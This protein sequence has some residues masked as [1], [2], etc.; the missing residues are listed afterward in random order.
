MKGVHWKVIIGLVIAVIVM[1]IALYFLVYVENFDSLFLSN[2][3]RILKQY[4]TCALAYCATG[5]KVVDGT[6]IPSPQVESVGCL[7]SEGGKCTLSCAQ[8]KEKLG[9]ETEDADIFFDNRL[10]CGKDFAIPFEFSGI[11]LGGTVPFKSGQMDK[12]AKKPEWICKPVKIPFTDIYVDDILRSVPVLQGIPH[13]DTVSFQHGSAERNCIIKGGLRADQLG[14]LSLPGMVSESILRPKQEVSRGGGCFENVYYDTKV[15]PQSMYTPILEYKVSK[16]M[17][18]EDVKRISES[19][20]MYS[21]AIYLDYDS[22]FTRVLGDSSEPECEYV[23]PPTDGYSHVTQADIDR[24]VQKYLNKEIEINECRDGD[25]EGEKTC[26]TKKVF[27]GDTETQLNMLRTK[28]LTPEDQKKCEPGGF[29]IFRGITTDPSLNPKECAVAIPID[30]ISSEDLEKVRLRIYQIEFGD[31]KFPDSEKFGVPIDSCRFRTTIDGKK[32]PYRVWS[33]SVLPNVFFSFSTCKSVTLSRNLDGLVSIDE[34]DIQ[35]AVSSLSFGDPSP[36]VQGTGSETNAE[37]LGSSSIYYDENA[38][39]PFAG[40]SES[41]ILL[42]GESSEFAGEASGDGSSSEASVTSFNGGTYVA[43]TEQFQSSEIVVKG[44][45]GKM[46]LTDDIK[47]QGH[48]SIVSHN[49][50]LYVLYSEF[51]GGNSRILYKVGEEK[52]G[53]IEWSYSTDLVGNSLSS[54]GELDAISTQ[55]G[56]LMVYRYAVSGG[57]GDIWSAKFDGTDMRDAVKVTD[58]PSDQR[59]PSLVSFRGDIYVF[60]ATETGSTDLSRDPPVVSMKISY[61][62][63][64]GVNWDAAP[65]DLPTGDKTQI[66]QPEAYTDGS[67]LFVAFSSY[68]GETNKWDIL[69]VSGSPST[70]AE[71][72]TPPT[73]PETD[74]PGDDPPEEEQP[75]TKDPPKIPEPDQSSQ[76]DVKV[77]GL[78]WSDN[79]GKLSFSIVNSGKSEVELSDLY[80][81]VDSWPTG[82]TGASYDSKASQSDGKLKVSE[83]VSISV[84]KEKLGTLSGKTGFV[85]TA[86][87]KSGLKELDST[88]NVMDTSFEFPKTPVQADGSC[89]TIESNG[90][91]AD[92]LDVVF[93]PDG[94]SDMGRFVDHVKLSINTMK[95]IEPFKSNAKKMNFYYVAARNVKM[96]KSFNSEDAALVAQ[97]SAK[98]PAYDQKIVLSGRSGASIG[99]WARLSKGLAV[100]TTTVPGF[101]MDVVHELAHSFGGLLDEYF[102]PSTG[103]LYSEVSLKNTLAAGPN[104]DVSGCPRWCS[105]GVSANYAQYSAVCSAASS[106]SSCESIVRETFSCVWSADEFGKNHR[107]TIYSA[108]GSLGEDAEESFGLSCQSGLGCF[109]GCANSAANLFSPTRRSIMDGGNGDDPADLRFNKIGLDA[110]SKKLSGYK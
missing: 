1:A 74:V 79:D 28:D 44:P 86:Y 52:D 99:S 72:E 63:L 60:Y 84:G 93:L 89:V 43:Y 101:S 77:S 67:R 94:Y 33:D 11:S 87:F 30:Q 59:T 53:K 39:N 48:P 4:A 35:E 36:L 26:E 10:F 21:S 40:P 92:K 42:S 62:R 66:M 16:N 12:M 46:R 56:I 51:S 61:K 83:S 41:S 6:F 25:K 50:K 98:C 24:I 34:G 105:G 78:S 88:N 22:Q 20:K 9:W 54:T 64:S 95:L 15:G 102:Y 32:V 103:V 23:S 81:R 71:H 82:F 2:D 109:Q 49:G 37:T 13:V 8:V 96:I 55:D 108:G 18:A 90:N 5:G 97:Y 75:T 106:E 7:K 14:Y 73:L 58:D 80:F 38:G 107:C 17:P 3:Q 27:L 57:K 29:D 65:T 91:T 31:P 104:C 76:I 45:S 70:S 110:I 68:E 100:V 47:D 69:Q 85:A 19:I